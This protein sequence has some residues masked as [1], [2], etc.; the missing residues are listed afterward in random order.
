MELTVARGYIEPLLL[1]SRLYLLI[2]RETGRVR[3]RGRETWVDCSSH[4]SC[5]GTW[6]ETQTCALTGNRTSDV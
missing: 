3:K 1:L 6:P 5:W 4:A 2:F